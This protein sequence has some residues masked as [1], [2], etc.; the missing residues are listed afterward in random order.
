MARPHA[1]RTDRGSASGAGV[2]FIKLAAGDE[3]RV[4]R[5]VKLR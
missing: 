2:H 4:T 1:E 3:T 5:A